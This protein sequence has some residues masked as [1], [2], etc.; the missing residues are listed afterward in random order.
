M[1]IIALRF[2]SYKH[3]E[4]EM[5]KKRVAEAAASAAAASQGSQ[6][7][8]PHGPLDANSDR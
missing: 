3:H 2:H 8:L 5:E 7:G 6:N 1:I 4:M